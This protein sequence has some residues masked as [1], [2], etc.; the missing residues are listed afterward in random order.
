MN[1]NR[2]FEGEQLTIRAGFTINDQKN[3]KATEQPD[4]WDRNGCTHQLKTDK[5]TI[6]NNYKRTLGN[7]I[8]K[9]TKQLLEDD[10]SEFITLI[11]TWKGIITLY[12]FTKQAFNEMIEEYPDIVSYD[13]ASKKNGGQVTI[14]I[15]VKPKYKV[16]Y[17]RYYTNKLEV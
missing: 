6:A 16:A 8:K 15:K 13:R 5:A 1:K 7:N 3:A 2:G 12:S 10:C 4:A 14:R 17:E 11:A 9:E